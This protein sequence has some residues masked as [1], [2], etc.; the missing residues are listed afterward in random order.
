[1]S[2]PHI[3][4]KQSCLYQFFKPYQNFVSSSLRANHWI[5]MRQKL[6]LTRSFA[7]IL[8]ILYIIFFLSFS[9]SPFP[10]DRIPILSRES[11]RCTSILR[12]SRHERMTCINT[13]RETNNGCILPSQ[14]TDSK[15]ASLITSKN[16]IRY[17]SSTIILHPPL[18]A[19]LLAYSL[20]LSLVSVAFWFSKYS[21]FSNLPMDFLAPI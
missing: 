16:A 20:S 15:N 11:V 14:P 9:Y 1:M 5:I 18:T 21:R 3:S 12:L 13:N 17:V 19:K 10:V 7:C 6:I 2:H 8:Y 4:R